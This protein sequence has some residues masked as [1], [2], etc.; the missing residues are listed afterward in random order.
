MSRRPASV[1]QADVARIVR[2]ARQAGAQRVTVKVGE[3]E[4]VIDLGE[5]PSRPLARGVDRRREIVL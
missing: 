5:T 3:A 2:G 4:I 1:T